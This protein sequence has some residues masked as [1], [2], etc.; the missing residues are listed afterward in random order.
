MD[1]GLS[2]KGRLVAHVEWTLLQKGHK[3]VAVSAVNV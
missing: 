3:V 1:S 2:A